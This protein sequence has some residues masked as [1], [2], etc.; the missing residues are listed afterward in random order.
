MHDTE[1]ESNERA[2]KAV[3]KKASFGKDVDISRYKK[4][5][6]GTKRIEKE[7]R[8]KLLDVG[9]QEESRSGSYLQFDNSVV[10]ELQLQKGIEI[11]SIQK[12]M[13]K[14]DWLKDYWWKAVE[15]DQDK[16]TAYAQLHKPA[17]YFIRALPNSES[18]FPVQSCLYIKSNRIVQ[19]VHNVIIA[20]ENSKL[21]VITGCAA[22]EK[23][24]D[25]LHIG[26]SEFFVKKNATVSFTMIHSWGESVVVRPRSGTIIEE[27]GTFLS[28]YINMRRSKSIQM[29]PTSYCVGRNSI[30][31]YNTILVAKEGSRAD[32]G[33]RTVLRGEGSKTEMISRAISTGGEAYLRGDIKGEAPE[34]KGHIEC[35]GLMLEDKG[36]ICSIPELKGSFKDS[37]LSHEAA[38]GKIA[39]E[40]I[41]YLMSK[42]LS[43]EDATAAIVRG[44]LNVEIRGLPP[45]LDKEIKRTI[46]TSLKSML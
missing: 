38:I 23:T 6:Q 1:L 22:G 10:E 21:D 41:F 13:E 31:R 12:A 34:V 19:G 28:N 40:E 35:R 11:M 9:V 3:D 29:Y 16:F 25:A 33:S 37:D 18:K 4:E 15:V 26:I 24:K 7:D 44:F 20:E 46:E 14:Y 42:G 5:E 27:N 30:A 8:K 2:L 45:L 17:G 43:E 39:D 32:I 36:F